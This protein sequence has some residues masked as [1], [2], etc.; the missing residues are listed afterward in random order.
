MVKIQRPKR[1]AV[2]YEGKLIIVMESTVVTW[3]C[4]DKKIRVRKVVPI[5]SNNNLDILYL[6]VAPNP[7]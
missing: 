1:R 5:S 4:P 6:M 2:C 3:P 7:S